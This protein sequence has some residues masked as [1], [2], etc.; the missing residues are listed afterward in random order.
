M[1][2]LTKASLCA[3]R[4]ILHSLKGTGADSFQGLLAAVLPQICSQPFRLA[5]RGSQEGGTA[6]RRLIERDVLRS[7]ALPGGRSAR[8]GL[9]EIGRFDRRRQR[10]GGYL[11]SL[12]TARPICELGPAQ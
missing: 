2:D 10:A 9:A 4:D 7:E 12:L 3:L 6:T 8:G 11:G 5:S 1:D